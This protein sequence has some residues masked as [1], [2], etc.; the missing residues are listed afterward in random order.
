[1]ER[2]VRSPHRICSH[3]LHN[4]LFTSENQLEFES[5]T[6]HSIIYKT[7]TQGGFDSRIGYVVDYINHLCADLEEE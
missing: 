2:W 3:S 6:G 4:F 1:M 5:T 7:K